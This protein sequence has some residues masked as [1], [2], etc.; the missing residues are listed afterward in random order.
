MSNKGSHIYIPR[1]L[2]E[3]LERGQAERHG[4]TL[5]EWRA[6]RAPINAQIEARRAHKERV[7][8]EAI[9]AFQ[10]GDLETYEVLLGIR[11][12]TFLQRL[13]SK[14]RHLKKGN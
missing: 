14:I 9:A 10:A 2:D 3:R 11:Q 13:L 4:L 1:D 5:D 8:R 12:P 7:T 6:F